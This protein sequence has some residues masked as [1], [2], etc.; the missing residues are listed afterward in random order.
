[1]SEYTGSK[2]LLNCVSV[3][4]H[5][6]RFAHEDPKKGKGTEDE[7]LPTLRKRWE[8]K[9]GQVL[10]RSH[11]EIRLIQRNE[12]IPARTLRQ[13]I[14]LAQCSSSC[15][16]PLRYCFPAYTHPAMQKPTKVRGTLGLYNVHPARTA[17]V[18]MGLAC[19]CG[20]GGDASSGY[21]FGK[22]PTEVLQR[23]MHDWL[24]DA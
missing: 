1:M 8:D 18:K 7:E 14:C 23:T 20:Q 22:W 11:D 17:K 19:T 2:W 6:S 3:L 5:G 15:L 4:P 9:P 13:V 24:H 10:A 21:H 16:P 12:P